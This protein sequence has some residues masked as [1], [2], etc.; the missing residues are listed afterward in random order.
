MSLP[1][2]PEMQHIMI[3]GIAIGILTEAQTKAYGKAC[4]EQALEEAAQA[5]ESVDLYLRSFL[6]HSDPRMTCAQ[7]IRSLK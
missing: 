7:A 6:K 3:R 4:R 1:Q 2:L 5:A